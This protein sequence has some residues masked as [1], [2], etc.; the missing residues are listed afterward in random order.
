MGSDADPYQ[1]AT[2]YNI[3]QA[4]NG[5]PIQASSTTR[6][7]PSIKPERTQSAEIGA[8][9]G[10]FN[11]RLSVD[12][13]LYNTNSIDQILNVQTSAASGYSYQLINA[14][15]INN[16]G[17]EIQL[18]A[19]PVKTDHFKYEL[20]VNYSAN[21][22]QVIELDAEGLLTR[23]VIGAAGPQIVAE[24]GKRYGAIYGVAYKR[25]EKGEILV[26]DNGLPLRDATNKILGYFTPDWTGA[27]TNTFSYKNWSLSALIDASVGASLYSSSAATGVRAGV[28][29]STVFG[30]SAEFGGLTWTDANGT[31]DDGV[32][33]PGVNENTGRAND[34]KLSAESYYNASN[35]IH[36][37]Y[38]YDA[39]YVK[40]RDIRIAYT[41]DSK[42][43][44][45]LG[46]QGL[47]IAAVAHNLA[48][49]YRDKDLNM[50]PEAGLNTGNV[51][52]VEA[53]T[54]PTTRS[55]GLNINLKF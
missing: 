5:N 8:E 40:L 24:V 4:F 11:N 52:G 51:Q 44:A 16:K 12:L 43:A 36:E 45:R 6:N 30:R 34:V 26:G 22:S 37:K 10:F 18:H 7:N 41:F 42:T 14:G 1:L 49:L 2:V 13:A 19:T 38:V 47:T 25:N 55:F 48:I 28:Y 39:S 54:R 53:L 23:Y 50:D 3:S 33:F 35:G 15:S 46:L 21:R 20:G 27:V 29:A 17:I 9:A 32:I 31:R